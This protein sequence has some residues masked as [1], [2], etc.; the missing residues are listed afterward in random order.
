M[1]NGG[2]QYNVQVV[3]GNSNVTLQQLSQG[4][5]GVTQRTTGL[6]SAISKIGASA[7]VFN[8]IAQSIAGVTNAINQAIAPG[9]EL[10]SKLH[11]LKAITGATDDQLKLIKE[12]ARAS[13]KAFGIDASQS[14]ESYTLLLSKLGPTLAQTPK[15]LKEMGDQVSILSK[16][17]HGDTAGAAEILS[18]AM[19][20]YGISIKNPIEATRTMGVM[21]NIMSAAAQQGS[22]RLPQIKAALEASG[23]SAK[24]SNVS[25]AELNAAIQ[26][27]DKKG[28]TGA[29]GGV[30]IRNILADLSQGRFMHREE[31]K[32][33]EAYGISVNALGDTTKTFQQR[34]EMLKPIMHDHALI[35]KVFKKDNLEAGLALIGGTD[36]MGAYTKS[37]V[38][39]NTAITMAKDTM[40]SYTEQMNR[41]WAKVK[42]FGISIF[43][44]FRPILPAVQIFGAGIQFAAMFGGAL[45]TVCMIA[46][47]SF[48]AAMKKAATS[49]WGFAK[50]LL[51][52]ILGL[53]KTA[54]QFALTGAMMLGSYIVGLVSATAAQLGLNI[55]MDANPIGLIVIGIIAAVGVIVLMIKYWDHIKSAIVSFT[56]WVWHHSPF[57]FLIDVME[58][59]FP[60]FKTAMDNLWHWI[61][62]KFEALVGWLKT[63]FDWIKKLFTGSGSK[64]AASDAGKEAADA[65]QASMTAAMPGIDTPNAAEKNQKIMGGA[66]MDEAESSTKGI[67]EGGARPTNINIHIG[68]FQDKIEIHSVNIKE[69]IDDLVRVIEE[70][71][72]GILNSANAQGSR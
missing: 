63:A 37:F 64:D 36:Q 15:Q 3:S 5:E 26:V 53:A 11:D 65:Y 52:T 60:Q 44:S 20:Q 41:T 22:A 40:G 55:A 57:G 43:D 45:N 18:T 38:H 72:L 12:S 58:K 13:A 31:K 46:N 47:S 32:A 10:D 17:L 1:S 33:L 39:T 29:D 28:K 2:V 66:G 16:Q 8:N 56:K 7:F 34:L 49:T 67:S 23:M 54:L 24:A 30:A 48:G 70:R 9:I 68:K 71:F 51:S 50:S 14:V 27:L 21:M 6:G 59:V 19:N 42:D 35:T 69:G 62:A 61:T 4:I 25:F